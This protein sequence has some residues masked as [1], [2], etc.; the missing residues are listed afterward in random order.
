[1]PRMFRAPPVLQV[2]GV[3]P[4]GVHNAPVRVRNRVGGL[5]DVNYP[6]PNGQ[7]SSGFW[8]YNESTS[9]GDGSQGGA[10]PPTMPP[11]VGAAPP[12]LSEQ[13]LDLISTPNGQSTRPWF[14]PCTYAGFPFFAAD[15]VIR[16]VLSANLQ[17]NSLIIENNSTAD[18]TVGDVAPSLYIGFNN[19][20]GL[21]TGAL[22]LPPGLG[23][24][25]SASD[26]P[27]R[28]D[29]FAV[30]FGTING[31][32]TVVVSSSII[33]GTYIPSTALSSSGGASSVYLG[34]KIPGT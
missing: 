31:G 7:P 2:K 25:W 11:S 5:A 19:E 17:R 29:I 16:K 9:W 3:S 22:V 13:Q 28:D 10:S 12:G 33:Q 21:Q 23:F 34:A 27:P 20:P 30:F 32:A 6:G 26:C 4:P 15:G 8:P 24:Y 14:N 1:M 18:A